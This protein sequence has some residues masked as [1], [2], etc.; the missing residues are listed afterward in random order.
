MASPKHRLRRSC[1]FCRARKIKCSNDSICEA[2]RRQGSDC[3]YDFE[4]TRTK[5]RN[6]SQDRGVRPPSESYISLGVSTFASPITGLG[7]GSLDQTGNFGP[8][9]LQDTV[10]AAL[11]STF[12]DNFVCGEGNSP[13]TSRSTLDCH[14]PRL[15]FEA[16]D[17]TF[18]TASE[19]QRDP[20]IAHTGILSLVS[21]D[22]IA[23]A[24]EQFGALGCHSR[25]AQAGFFVSAL[26]KDETPTMFDKYE[27]AE[28]PSPSPEPLTDLGQ[29]Q[30]TQLIDVWFSHYPLSCTVSK[31]LFLRELRDGTHDDVLLAVILGEASLQIGDDAQGH[32][33]LG[34]AASQLG[35]R[36][37]RG[38]GQASNGIAIDDSLSP[39]FSEISTRIFH[40]ISTVQVLVLLGW[41]AL[42][43]S[44]VRRAICYIGLAGAIVADLKEQIATTADPRASSR[45]NGID[46]FVVEKELIDHL[47][48]TTYATCLW[49]FVQTGDQRFAPPLPAAQPS[50][51][52]SEAED[53]SAML[54]LDKVSGNFNTLHQQ[55]VAICETWP[56]AHIS[57]VVAYMCTFCPRRSDMA[58]WQ[59]GPVRTYPVDALVSCQEVSRVLSK[60]IEHFEC[61]AGDSVSHQLVLTAYH[62][63]AIHLLF[64][65]Q[66]DSSN[67]DTPARFCASAGVILQ[68]LRDANQPRR[69]TQTS[70]KLLSLL[71]PEMLVLALDTCTRALGFKDRHGGLATASRTDVLGSVA[72]QLYASAK[73]DF[74]GQCDSLRATKK[75]LRLFLSTIRNGAATAFAQRSDCR[76]SLPDLPPSLD[77]L[78]TQVASHSQIDHVS[79]WMPIQETGAA[80]TASKSPVLSVAAAASSA[81]PADSDRFSTASTAALDAQISS[82]H[83]HDK[84]KQLSPVLPPG[85][86]PFGSSRAGMSMNSAALANTGLLSPTDV[87]KTSWQPSDSHELF[88]ATKAIHAGALGVSRQP[89]STIPTM[90]TQSNDAVLTQGASWFPQLSPGTMMDIDMATSVPWGEW[91]DSTAHASADDALEMGMAKS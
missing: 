59:S 24:A 54:R 10:A 29:R 72:E 11:E 85:S 87:F 38:S 6:S 1:A 78:A 62:T 7:K 64:P 65:L 19:V 60:S 71:L 86:L 26:E 45:I 23:L 83:T 63:L 75:Q 84:K 48:W 32:S 43:S 9:I 82:S 47:Y 44:H 3:I 15:K 20:D 57:S 5:I 77:G 91:T 17:D 35:S 40:N 4:S 8:G 21:R 74:L 25:N 52:V 51:F 28:E 18:S 70:Y 39:P 13:S 22:L 58:Q 41:N 49:A 81:S 90:P 56:L 27:V 2:C 79:T 73:Y 37:L 69:K 16:V 12:L 67:S 14:S 61:Q 89:V 46:V 66:G 31:T 50:I 34:W 80:A 76:A 88:D 42:A 30:Q 53:D 36:S 68:A 33:L 55:S